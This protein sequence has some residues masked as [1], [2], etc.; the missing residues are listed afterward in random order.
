MEMVLAGLKENYFRRICQHP[1]GIWIKPAD[2]NATQLLPAD[3]NGTGGI[4]SKYEQ[5]DRRKYLLLP[6]LCPDHNGRILGTIRR[7]EVSDK[8]DTRQW[9]SSIACGRTLG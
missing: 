7:I 5:P 2:S 3:L 4:I 9:W 8:N 1:V 6:G